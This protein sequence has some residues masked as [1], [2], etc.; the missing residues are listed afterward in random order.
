MPCHVRKVDSHSLA[1]PVD[2]CPEF[3]HPGDVNE[4]QH[5]TYNLAQV[6]HHSPDT[7][8]NEIAMPIYH[9]MI[10]RHPAHVFSFVRPQHSFVLLCC[11]A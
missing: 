5:A 9:L 8:L 3:T 7:A 4:S 10:R 2:S 1:T 11:V 6:Y